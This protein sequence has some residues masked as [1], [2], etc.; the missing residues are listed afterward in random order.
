MTSLRLAHCSD[1]HLHFAAP[2]PRPAEWLSKRSL[3]RLS[4][5]RGRGRLQRP[6]LLALAV[7]D[8][9]AQAP[10]HVLVSGDITN[11]SLPGE[12]E[13]AARWLSTLGTATT[14]SVIPGNHDA[15]VPV[16]AARGLDHWRPW[17]QG[18]TPSRPPFPYLRRR[19]GVALIGLSSAIPTAPG[20]AGGRL[21]DPQL[22]ALEDLLDGLKTEGCC[23]VVTL[24]HPPADGVVPARKALWDRA[25][26]RAVL[27]R[28][29]AELVLHGHSRDSRFDL[30]PGPQGLIPSLGMPSVS[31]LPNPKDEGAR[32]QLLEFSGRPGDWWLRVT[33]RALNAARD[34]FERVGGYRLRLST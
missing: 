3:S 9:R 6:E 22:R 29:G 33:V 32:W 2:S 15:L 34:G 24:H 21:G 7:A 10:D 26:L 18:D 27:A 12:F 14:L 23:R 30:L 4:W 8:L 17:M 31:A 20:L 5:A 19:G 1:P 28:A 16:P 25:G 13:N 11:F